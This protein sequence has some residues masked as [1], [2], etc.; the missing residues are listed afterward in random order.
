MPPITEIKDGQVRYE[1]NVYSFGHIPSEA[2]KRDNDLNE[3]LKKEIKRFIS[4]S[5]IVHEK[6]NRVRLYWTVGN[7]LRNILDNSGLVDQRDKSL[8][9]SN[10]RLHLDTK[11]F[12]E[13]DLSKRRNIPEH[14][15]KLSGYREDLAV[16]VNWTAWSYL[17][18]SPIIINNKKFDEWFQ[19]ILATNN[20]EFDQAFSRIWAQSFTTLFKDID[21]RNWGDEEFLKP[22][23]CTLEI[24]QRMKESGIDIS[25]TE[26]RDKLRL[27]LKNHKKEFILLTMGEIKEDVFIETILKKFMLNKRSFS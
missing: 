8:F 21:L 22:I 20:Y 6:K 11:I 14:F 5:N 17:F 19:N 27:F 10:A 12:P 4:I 24:V 18:D 15:Y 9:F 23:R 16:K 13:S 3:L 2:K 7:I 26:T 25:E 1:S